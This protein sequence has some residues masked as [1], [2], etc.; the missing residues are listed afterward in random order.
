MHSWR[1]FPTPTEIDGHGYMDGQ[2]VWGSSKRGSSEFSSFHSFIYHQASSA[3]NASQIS[4]A[5]S[6]PSTSHVSFED[7]Q[8]HQFISSKS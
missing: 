6:N 1:H 5:R 2:G 4:N 7:R 8:M 3:R